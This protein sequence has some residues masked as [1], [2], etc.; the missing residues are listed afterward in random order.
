[1]KAEVFVF[2][3]LI[4]VLHNAKLYGEQEQTG[5]NLFGHSVSVF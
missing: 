1:M 2:F 5:A 3:F 4:T